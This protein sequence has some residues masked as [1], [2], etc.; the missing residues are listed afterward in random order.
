MS[1]T[2]AMTNVEKVRIAIAQHTGGSLMEGEQAEAAPPACACPSAADP[3]ERQCPATLLEAS[4]SAK[5]TAI[6]HGR[7]ARSPRLRPAAGGR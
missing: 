5:G 1:A 2:D 4:A 6:R 7:P 3:R